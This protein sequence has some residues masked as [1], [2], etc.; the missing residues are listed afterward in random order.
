ML[1][2]FVQLLWPFLFLSRHDSQSLFY[3]YFVYDL[4]PALFCFDFVQVLNSSHPVDLGQDEEF[5]VNQQ[6]TPADAR[7]LHEYLE[8]QGANSRL[9]LLN[10]KKFISSRKPEADVS[11]TAHRS[12]I[13]NLVIG[14]NQ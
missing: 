6:A 13:H 8:H 9:M 14:H 3:T 12:K 10:R 2:W 4:T 11:W 7:A 1:D 5:V